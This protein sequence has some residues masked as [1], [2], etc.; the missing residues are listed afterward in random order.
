M[1]EKERN[2]VEEQLAFS[3]ADEEAERMAIPIDE[4]GRPIGRDKPLFEGLKERKARLHKEEDE[5]KE[6]YEK[7]KKE[8]IERADGYGRLDNN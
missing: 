2:P 7:L 8:S 4:E 6:F 1:S 5:K 3:F